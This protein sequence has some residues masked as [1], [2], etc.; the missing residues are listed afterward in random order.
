[1]NFW[2]KLFDKTPRCNLCGKETPSGSSNLLLHLR[3][4]HPQV[5]DANIWFYLVLLYCVHIFAFSPTLEGKKR[6]QHFKDVDSPDSIQPWQ[7][8]GELVQ[9]PMVKME[10]DLKRELEVDVKIEPQDEVADSV[11]DSSSHPCWTYKKESDQQ[12]PSVEGHFNKKYLEGEKSG[13]ISK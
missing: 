9:Q 10:A 3:H 13:W 11:S 4:H 2:C 7:E 6:F 1:M 8:H 5:N 12:K